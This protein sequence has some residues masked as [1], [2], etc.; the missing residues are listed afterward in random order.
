M[1]ILI[2]A[3][4]SFASRERAMLS[5][6]EV[7]LADESVRVVHAI[8]ERCARWHHPEV[9]SQLITYED[10]GLVISRSWRAQRI[11]QDLGT[12]AE[13]GPRSLDIVH[14]FGRG[15]WQL[16]AEVARQTGAA[17]AVEI[18]DPRDAAAGVRLRTGDGGAPVFFTPDAALERL[19]HA[20]DTAASVRVTPWGVHTPPVPREILTPGRDASIMIDGCGRDSAG[21]I[22]LM[23]GIAAVAP[24]HPGLM[25]FAE[26]EAIRIAGVWPLVKKLGLSER[27]TLTP[28]LEARREL[29]LRAD[30]LILPEALGEHR[31][32]TLDAMAAGMVVIAAADPL[33]GVLIDARTARLVE[34]P[35]AEK[36]EEA[37][38]WLLR[39]RDQARALAGLARQYT[40]QHCRASAYVSAVM[41]AYE[42]MTAGES[43][44]FQSPRA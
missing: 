29:T 21:M 39:Q 40:A 4:E 38:I 26:A 41:D 35:S 37:L 36:W 17:L 24:A 28:D 2:M 1:R 31:S 16:A 32:L 15:S 34:R 14:A 30:A 9:Q 44:P 13:P 20:D 12:P 18:A 5:R 3:D 42:W 8:P 22:A 6:L 27:F 7:G 25:V 10:R 43:I 23:R 33:V 19:I 11:V